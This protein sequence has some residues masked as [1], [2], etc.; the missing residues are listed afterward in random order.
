LATAYWP[1]P[2]YLP[3]SYRTKGEIRKKLQI[4]LILSQLAV[5]RRELRETLHAYEARLEIMLA[6]IANEVTTLK[7]AKRL[8]REQLDQ[9]DS[10][11]ALLR[12]RKLKPEKGRR[13][14][15]RKIEKLTNDLHA[16]ARP[17]FSR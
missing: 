15:L 11:V 3:L 14:D 1:I 12:K 17:K 6:E 16:A 2:S 8:S 10:A 5:L 9:I 4:Q 7:T 13:K